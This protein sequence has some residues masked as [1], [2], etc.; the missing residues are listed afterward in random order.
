MRIKEIKTAKDL[1]AA[2]KE[3]LK[4]LKT[5]DGEDSPRYRSVV[6]FLESRAAYLDAIKEGEDEHEARMRAAKHWNAWANELIRKREIL[7]KDKKWDVSFDAGNSVSTNDN[8]EN[9]ISERIVDFSDIEFLELEHISCINHESLQIYVDIISFNMFIFP[10]VTVFERAIFRSYTNM[11][12]MEIIGKCIF[13]ECHFKLIS[14]QGTI[15]NNDTMFLKC[16]FDD[17]S[18]LSKTYYKNNISFRFSTFNEFITFSDCYF[19]KEAN[20]QY[21]QSR[22]GFS[23]YNSDFWFVPDFNGAVF[24]SP[25]EL[26]FIKISENDFMRNVIFKYDIEEYRSIVFNPKQ[27]STIL[28]NRYRIL[29]MHAHEAHDWLNE[30]KFFSLEIRSRRYGLDFPIGEK[31]GTLIRKLCYKICSFLFPKIGI[32]DHIHRIIQLY[33]RKR[34]GHNTGRFWFSVL[35]E[36]LSNFGQSFLRPV[37]WWLVFFVFFACLYEWLAVCKSWG[38]AFTVSLR[39]GLVISGLVRTGHYV[40]ILKGLFGPHMSNWAFILLNLQTVVSAVFLFLL[41]L[42]VRN[43]FRIR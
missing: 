41:L 12:Y 8:G 29:G 9:Y 33:F 34:T 14:M 31:L 21:I 36:W 38:A 16:I 22:K 6:R 3:S 26:N 20:F 17:I 11:E 4:R 40:E 1:W 19:F 43:H 25:I 10:G 24:I 7:L 32:H 42:A 30:M 23:L 35:Y 27:S 39:Q 2:N 5:E 13:A 37:V 28:S 15:F 18:N